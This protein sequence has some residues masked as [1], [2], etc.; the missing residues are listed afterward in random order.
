MYSA[1]YQ[2]HKEAARVGWPL[3]YPEDLTRHDHDYLAKYTPDRFVWVLRANGTHLLLAE[4]ERWA[5]DWLLSVR[6]SEGIA[7][8]KDDAPM[9]SQRYYIF[10]D[11][12]LREVAFSEAREFLWHHTS[13]YVMQEATDSARARMR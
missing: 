6:R 1:Y 9:P 8:L 7:D 13:E 10:E 12:L 5:H 2:L 4:K 3:A 11:N